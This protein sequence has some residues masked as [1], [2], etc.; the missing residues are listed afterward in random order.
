MDF[1][2]CYNNGMIHLIVGPMFSGKSTELFRLTNRHILAGKSVIIVKYEKDNRYDE[3]LASTHDKRTMKAISALHLKNILDQIKNYDVIGIDE[4][5][6]FD[7]IV[8]V[9][10]YLANMGKVVIVAALDGD[11]Q[12]RPF[13]NITNIYPLCEKIEKLSAVCRSCGGFA[14]FTFR[15]IMNSEVEVIGGNDIYKA[16]CRSCY[17]KFKMELNFKNKDHNMEGCDNDN[18][19]MKSIFE[20]NKDN[21]NVDPSLCH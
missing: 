6:F 12:R 14:S 11:F 9:C 2:N 20:F 1:S 3:E 18:S 10:E 13:K 19:T 16:V 5:Q 17:A 15:T 21:E 7:D 4:G 8:E